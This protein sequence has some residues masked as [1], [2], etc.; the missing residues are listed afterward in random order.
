MKSKKQKKTVTTFFKNLISK[1]I[2]ECII[3]LIVNG[4]H[5]TR[6]TLDRQWIGLGLA[7]FGQQIGV[8]H[9]KRINTLLFWFLFRFAFKLLI[10]RWLW[11]L[12]LF[13]LVPVYFDSFVCQRCRAFGESLFLFKY[14]IEVREFNKALETLEIREANKNKTNEFSLFSSLER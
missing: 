9:L 10:R 12:I 14:R 1:E 13:R 6:A 11:L 3:I 8:F 5:F 7:F 4:R 2:L